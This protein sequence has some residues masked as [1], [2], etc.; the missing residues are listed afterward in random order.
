VIT[1]RRGYK[2][3]VTAFVLLA[4][5]LAAADRLVLPAPA[6]AA[7]ATLEAAAQTGARTIWDGVYTTEQAG[8]GELE[9]KRS[10]GYCHKDDLSGGYFDDGTGRAPALAGPRAFDSSFEKR[11]NDLSVGEMLADIGGKMPLQDPA[12]LSVQAYAD[13]ISYLFAQ[14][15]VPPGTEELPADLEKLGTIRITPKPAR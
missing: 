14:N 7:A 5:A 9:Y 1:E 6:P 8:R 2:K 15:D 10:C 11:W 12:S 4:G 13:I 3:R